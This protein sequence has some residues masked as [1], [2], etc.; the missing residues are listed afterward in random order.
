MTVTG[1]DHR[2]R[3]R[4]PALEGMHITLQSAVGNESFIELPIIP[5]A[6]SGVRQA[7]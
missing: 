2:E 6:R 4:D 7:S 5:D 3:A 1:S